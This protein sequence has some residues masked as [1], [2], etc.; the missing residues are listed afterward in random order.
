MFS[1]IPV[2]N[3]RTGLVTEPQLFSIVSDS[4][5]MILTT[6]VPRVVLKWTILDGGRETVQNIRLWQI[7]LESRH[8]SLIEDGSEL[9]FSGSQVTLDH[10]VRDGSSSRLH[11]S[12]V[13]FI[14]AQIQM[15]D[16]HI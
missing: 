7:L 5:R 12:G 3:P 15:S 16:F 1:I 13:L 9:T 8:T 11:R 6:I 14:V 2:G 10:P 4:C